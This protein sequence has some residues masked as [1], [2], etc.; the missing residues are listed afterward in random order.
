MRRRKGFTLVELLVVIG[1]IAALIAIL[2]PALT[3]ARNQAITIKCASNLHNMGLAMTMY[4]TNYR[5][6]PG[7]GAFSN[8]IFAVWP[9]RLRPFLNNDQGVFFCPAQDP[10]F[11][12][13]V[14]TNGN[15]TANESGYGYNQ[16]ERLLD[17]FTVFFSYGY[18]DW[19]VQRGGQGVVPV[20]EQHGLGG[21]IDPNR[22]GQK[23]MKASKVKKSSDMMAI[24]D[25]TCDTHWDFNV[26][27]LDPFEYPG[28]IHS[29]GSN[30]LFCDGHV[31]WY[32]QKDLINVGSGPTGTS[33]QMQMNRL[34]N[35]DN[36]PH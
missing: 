17:V 21:D 16:G 1:I 5:Y 29:K 24:M 18:N 25:N 26:D 9:T 15:A 36:E 23:E 4:T 7:H 31:T 30:V 27:P 33:A 2:M 28:K 35:N 11:E 6:Y 14:T 3:K 12:W 20:E 10:N 32:L 22:A 8:G 19:G 34:W 13:Q